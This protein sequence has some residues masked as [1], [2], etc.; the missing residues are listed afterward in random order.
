MYWN[1]EIVELIRIIKERK[2]TTNEINTYYKFNSSLIFAYSISL[3]A[4]K[5]N[6]SDISNELNAYSLLKEYDFFKTHDLNASDDSSKEKYKKCWIDLLN[7]D[8]KKYVDFEPVSYSKEIQENWLNLLIN[9]WE[10]E[11]KYK[12]DSEKAIKERKLLINKLSKL[13]QS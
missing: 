6:L 5:D 9:D 4:N 7:L 2:L 3:I 12:E 10:Y 11:N 1:P 8:F 13:M